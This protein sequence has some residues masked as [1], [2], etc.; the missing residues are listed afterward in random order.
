VPPRTDTAPA[1][2]PG[3][4]VTVAG[5]SA[6]VRDLDLLEQAGAVLLDEQRTRA[7]WR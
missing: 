4:T 3:E 1:P 5:G 7:G 6:S 2:A